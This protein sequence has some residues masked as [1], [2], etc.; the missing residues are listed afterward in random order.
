M[1]LALALA[2]VFGTVPVAAA[3][4]GRWW[5]GAALA[6]VPAAVFVYLLTLMERARDGDPLTWSIEWVPAL[7]ISLAFRADGLALLFGLLIAGIGALVLVYAE[8]YMA[9][10][11]AAGRLEAFREAFEE[12]VASAGTE[13]AL[14]PA[15]SVDAPLEIDDI[16]ASTLAEIEALTPFGTGNPEP[17]FV[18]HEVE[19]VTATRLAQGHLRLRLRRAGSGERGRTLSAVWFRPDPR[20]AECGRFARLLYRLR[21]GRGH[22]PSPELLVEDADPG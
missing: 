22:G 13:G 10:K 16:A 8:A 4:P 17:L 11:A 5:R 12:A 14:D 18:A 20:A 15:W 2:G 19:A 3:L 9:G 6:C 7:G 21:A 1:G